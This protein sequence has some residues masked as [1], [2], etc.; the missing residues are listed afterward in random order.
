MRLKTQVIVN[1]ESNQG[2]TRKRWAVIRTSIKG[3]IQEEGEESL[4]ELDGEQ[5]G[6]LPATFEI[7]PQRMLVKGYP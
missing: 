5:L 7:D 1:L 6:K 3:F 2:R 4:L